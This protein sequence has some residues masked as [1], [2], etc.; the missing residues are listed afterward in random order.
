MKKIRSFFNETVVKT[1][2][3]AIFSRLIA[4]PYQRGKV[5]LKDSSFSIYIVAIIST[6]HSTQITLRVT[7]SGN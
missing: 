7:L 1:K 3:E 4:K 2:N 5:W 6:N